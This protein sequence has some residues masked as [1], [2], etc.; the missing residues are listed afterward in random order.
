MP[1]NS[2]GYPGN[3]PHGLLFHRFHQSGSK[4]PSQGS[5]TEIEF[6]KILNY[7]GIER[8]KDS[9][10]W[11]ARIERG[12][13]E[14]TDL[15][16]TFDDGLKCQ[17]DIALPILDRYNIKAFWFIFSSVFEGGVDKN[18]IYNRF[19]VSEFNDFDSFVDS[20]LSQLSLPE[21]I[22]ADEPYLEYYENTKAHHDFYSENDLKFRYVRSYF[23]SRDQFE[24][25]MDKFLT[26]RKRSISE[27][28]D[29]LWMNNDDLRRLHQEG[30]VIGMHSYSH[31]YVLKNLQKDEQ[32][33]EY[34]KNLEHIA[35][36]INHPVSSMSHPL[37]SFGPET[38]DI[39][40][41]LN[42][43]CGFRADNS[44]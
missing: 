34:V 35:T 27:I 22:F 28:A 10:E 44:S 41:S 11:L 30:H 26:K 1:K 8:I 17:I 24:H 31:P 19:A 13:L 33:A 42:V 37:N 43:T 3:Q 4:S 14:N 21:S 2:N 6:D 15:C 16:I 18:E 20:F 39:L 7:V 36:T 29:R 38:L 9:R 5:I 23:F 12:G 32:E 25:E 40:T